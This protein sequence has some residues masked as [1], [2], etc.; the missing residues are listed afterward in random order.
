MNRRGFLKRLG[1]AFGAVMLPTTLLSYDPVKQS[2]VKPKVDN[3]P[4]LGYKGSQFMEVGYVYCP[5]LPLVQTCN[6]K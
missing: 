4:L 6:I 1:V 5:Y 2:V 3:S